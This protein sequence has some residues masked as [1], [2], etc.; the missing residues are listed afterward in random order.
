[1]I[2]L[3]RMFS[4]NMFVIFLT[5]VFFIFSNCN[6]IDKNDYSF[7]ET[8]INPDISDLDG[9]FDNVTENPDLDSVPESTVLDE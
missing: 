4:K 9:E 7:Y 2:Q 8:F 5:Y 3:N 1:M 6:Y